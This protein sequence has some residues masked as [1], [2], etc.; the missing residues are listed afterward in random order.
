VL[1][2]ISKMPVTKDNLKQSGLGKVVML[3]YKHPTETPALK[4][5]LKK[6]I[7]DWSRPIFKKSDKMSDLDRYDRPTVAIAAAAS[8]RGSAPKVAKKQDLDSLITSGKSKEA[9]LSASQQRA[10]VPF[11]RGFSYQVRPA[12][13]SSSPSKPAVGQASG[14]EIRDKLKKRMVEKGRKVSKNQRS[15]TLSVE[16]RATK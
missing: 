3:L 11:S 12:D 9:T 2:S 4:R 6:L 5:Q 7:E 13:R 14:G 16:G 8:G 15:A 1:E 10:Q